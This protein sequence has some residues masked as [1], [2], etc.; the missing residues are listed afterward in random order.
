MHA[1]RLLVALAFTYLVVP[2][3]LAQRQASGAPEAL[4]DAMTGR[5]VMLDRGGV[6]AAVVSI[7]NP[8]LWFG[9]AGQTR[10]LARVCNEYGARLVLNNPTRLPSAAEGKVAGTGGVV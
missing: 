1:R 8:G 10:R 3:A 4:L 7:T 2:A 6:A 9:D 5:W